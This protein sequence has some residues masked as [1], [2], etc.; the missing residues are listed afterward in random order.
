MTVGTFHSLWCH[1][2][3]CPRA[4]GCGPRLGCTLPQPDLVDIDVSQIMRS[5]SSNCPGGGEKGGDRVEN[6]G[7][8]WSLVLVN[9][10]RFVSTEATGLLTLFLSWWVRAPLI[11]WFLDG[12]GVDAAPFCLPL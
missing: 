12:S 8:Y 10:D 9:L 1:C 2:I 4:N 5:F 7:R 3:V 11:F 6:K